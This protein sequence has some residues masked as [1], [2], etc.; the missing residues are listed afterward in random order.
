MSYGGARPW[1]PLGGSSSGG[2]ERK[3]SVLES[4][5]GCVKHTVVVLVHGSHSVEATVVVVALVV[6]NRLLVIE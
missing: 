1:V 2:L 4:I 5:G 6:W 3:V